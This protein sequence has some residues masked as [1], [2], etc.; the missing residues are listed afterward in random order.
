MTGSFILDYYFLVL[1][2]SC[3]LFQIVG[4]L[5]GYRGMAFFDNRFASA[6]IGAAALIGA[7]A[8]FFLSQDRN[9]PDS[10]LGMNGN[11]QFAYFFAGSGTGLAITLILTSLRQLNF[12]AQQRELPPGLDALKETTFLLLI[13]RLIRRRGASNSTLD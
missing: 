13:F 1:I 6:C 2:A 10:D 7:F 4:A 5:H 9:V 11:E 12:G 8:W 3:G